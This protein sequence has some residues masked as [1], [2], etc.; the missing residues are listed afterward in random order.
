MSF[1][2]AKLRRFSCLR[3]KCCDGIRAVRPALVAASCHLAAEKGNACHRP[4]P[5]RQSVRGRRSNAA[6]LAAAVSTFCAFRS[7]AF[8]CVPRRE[9]AWRELWEISWSTTCVRI[10]GRRSTGGATARSSA[11]STRTTSCASFKKFPAGSKVPSDVS[12][13]FKFLGLLNRNV[14][15]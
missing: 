1:P 8:T 14:D 15:A 12:L 9:F 11:P 3:K 4:G 7:T 13:N 2:V 6:P 5:R 10:G